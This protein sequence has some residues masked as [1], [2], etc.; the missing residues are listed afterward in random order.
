MRKFVLG[1]IVCLSITLIFYI[2]IFSFNEEYKFKKIMIKKGY[3]DKEIIT[4]MKIIPER[5]YDIILQKQYNDSLFDIILNSDFKEDRLKDYLDYYEKN[6]DE[7][8]D[9]IITI[10]NSGYNLD[11][12]PASSLLSKLVREKY[13][14]YDNT[15][16]YLDYGNSHN[17]SSS[18]IISIVN[19]NA[20]LGFYNKSFESDLNDNNLIL[21]NKFYYLNKSYEPDDL[22]VLSGQYNGGVNNRLRKEAAD[23]F[24]EM[25]SAAM[26]DN[27]II[28]NISAYR[29]YDY[30]VN[31]YNRYVSRDGVEKAD[32]YSARAGYSE[33]Q[34]GLC[35]D[36][37]EVDDSFENTQEEKWLK[38]NAY[39]YGFILRFPK[40]KEDITGYKYEPWHY[41]YVGKGAAK[42]IFDN[43]LTLEEYYAYYV[44]K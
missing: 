20:D 36:I 8:I 31:L 39:K 14:I 12:Y 32:I 5:D 2:I 38:N 11:N 16:R 42:V 23:A 15:A 43:D 27:I 26:L 28:K 10:V 13:Y 37:N 22:V 33:H 6:N 40:N 30:Q 25:A 35:L 34:T 44:K 17:V 9:N 1:V 4:I 41:R 18:K 7:N 24:M 21:V 29:S 3:S 19:A